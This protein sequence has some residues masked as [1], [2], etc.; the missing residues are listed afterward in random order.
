[1]RVVPWMRV[2][3]ICLPPVQNV[4]VLLGQTSERTAPQSVALNVADTSFDLTLVS[5]HPGLGRQDHRAVVLTE[6]L[7]L[8]MQIRIVPVLLTDRHLKIIDH[9]G[10]RLIYAGSH[11]FLFGLQ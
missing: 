8:R 11:K 4:L 1:M 5:G 10:L 2:S 7:G 9:C 3:A 6:R